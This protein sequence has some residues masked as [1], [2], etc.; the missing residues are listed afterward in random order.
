MGFQQLQGKDFSCQTTTLGLSPLPFNT[1]FL[2]CTPLYRTCPITSSFPDCK[3][4]QSGVSNSTLPVEE[5]PH[6]E[7]TLRGRHA[8]ASTVSLAPEADPEC[9]S[10]SSELLPHSKHLC[11]LGWEPHRTPRTQTVLTSS[12]FT[13][14][15]FYHK[16]RNSLP[17]QP[18]G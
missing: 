4:E 7:L 18:A 1:A 11:F 15:T 8:E 12:F 9:R 10:P 2:L 16:L 14:S 17:G 13:P 3:K 5:Q 6:C